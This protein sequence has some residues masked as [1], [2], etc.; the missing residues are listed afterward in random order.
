MSPCATIMRLSSQAIKQMAQ[1]MSKKVSGVQLVQKAGGK[2]FNSSKES[3]LDKN[4][5]SIVSGRFSWFSDEKPQ[6]F[7]VLIVCCVQSMTCKVVCDVPTLHLG[8]SNFT[9]HC[10]AALCAKQHACKRPRF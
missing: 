10:C 9:R 3:D 1:K 7:V 5:G 8:S 4:L 6:E 2:P